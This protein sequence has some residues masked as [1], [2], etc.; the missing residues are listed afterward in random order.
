MTELESLASAMGPMVVT[1][2]TQMTIGPIS[3]GQATPKDQL[4]FVSGLTL[5][6]MLLETCTRRIR[7]RGY[8]LMTTKV[9]FP[10]RAI[11]GDFPA[12]SLFLLDSSRLQMHHLR[13]MCRLARH[14]LCR[15]RIS[16]IAWGSCLGSIQALS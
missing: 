13:G 1:S 15:C 10:Q 2:R 9:Q 7:P 14:N 4:Q 12:I 5:F 16:W 11:C 6:Q 8:L 3:F